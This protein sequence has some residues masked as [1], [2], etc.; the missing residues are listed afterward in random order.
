MIQMQQLFQSGQKVI[1]VTPNNELHIIYPDGDNSVYFYLRSKITSSYEFLI[2]WN[3]NKWNVT[4]HNKENA[5]VFFNIM[6]RY[7]QIYTNFVK[8]IFANKNTSKING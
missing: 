2:E 4:P 8:K 7:P 6:K 3:G 1:D 5:D